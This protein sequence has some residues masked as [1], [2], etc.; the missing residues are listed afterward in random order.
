MAIVQ[1]KPFDW[2]G[3]LTWLEN[4]SALLFQIVRILFKIGLKNAALKVA[5]SKVKEFEAYIALNNSLNKN[6]A[7]MQKFNVL[8][9]PNASNEEIID[10]ISD[11]FAVV[12]TVV[13]S[14][15]DGFQFTD[16]LTFVGQQPAIQEVIN[17]FPIFVEQFLA[18][19]PET[20]L[21]ATLKAR[22]RSTARYITLGKYGEGFYNILEM[23]ARSYGLGLNTY[24]E[25]KNV[26][27]AW[28]A[29]FANKVA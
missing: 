11:A 3:F 5:G 24:N 18:L 2:D 7:Q 26:L 6:S 29:I 4:N 19:N 12:Y 17:D 27:N 1:K 14:Q 16:I 15:K 10:S 21:D 20:A 23:V 9:K 8:I 13:D 22:A 28:K 25:G